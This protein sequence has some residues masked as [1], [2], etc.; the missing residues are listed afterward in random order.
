MLGS[1][2]LGTVTVCHVE[3]Q[4]GSLWNHPN[5]AQEIQPEQREEARLQILRRLPDD[6]SITE[7]AGILKWDRVRT[8]HKSTIY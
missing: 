2:S 6:R 1:V 8:N 7:T 5:E 3:S 4:R